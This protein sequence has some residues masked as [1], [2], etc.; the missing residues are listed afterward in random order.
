MTGMEAASTPD[1]GRTSHTGEL[2]RQLRETRSELQRTRQQLRAIRSSRSYRL[3]TMI[4]KTGRGPSRQAR[5][6]VASLLRAI[7][8]LVPERWRHALPGPVRGVVF[9]LTRSTTSGPA[10]SGRGTRA[11]GVSDRR[12]SGLLSLRAAGEGPVHLFVVLGMEA[13]ERERLVGDVLRLRE[14]AGG[15]LPVFVTDS[16]DFGVFRRH[17]LVFEYIPDVQRFAEH[18][19]PVEWPRHYDARMRGI[20]AQYEPEQVFVMG[21]WRADVLSGRTYLWPLVADA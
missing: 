2:E 15:F 6:A 14:V 11:V 12:G 16:D 10:S 13:E 3:A 8:R 1:A 18:A 7:A 21:D 4:A 9:R 20:L 17:Q 19:D 5:R